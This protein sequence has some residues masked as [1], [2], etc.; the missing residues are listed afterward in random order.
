MSHS[1]AYC[2]RTFDETEDGSFFCFDDSEATNDAG[3]VGKNA[4]QCCA[5][6]YCIFDI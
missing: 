4:S 5:N 1:A 2:T 3:T 6:I